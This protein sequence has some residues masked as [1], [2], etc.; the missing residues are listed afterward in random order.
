[1][2]AWEII[3]NIAEAIED[4]S[5][6]IHP[7]KH[8]AI[9]GRTHPLGAHPAYPEH[10]AGAGPGASNYEEVLASKQWQKILR[11]GQQYLGVPLTRQALPVIQ[12][13][14]MAALQLIAE[15]E[16]SHKEELEALA[17]ELVFELS[18][19][20]DAKEAYENGQIAI[21][22]QIVETPDLTGASTSGEEEE[23]EAEAPE[24]DPAAQDRI[25]KMVQRRHLTN[26]LI[27]GSAISN[28]FLFELG[29]QALDRIHPEL[30]KAYGVL[31][32][33]TEIGYWM[34]PQS[35]VIQG[36]RAELQV[37][38]TQVDYEEEGKPP[39]VK[40]QGKHF[41]V[42]I[43]ELIK[44]ITELASL[45]SLPQTDTEEFQEVM[46]KTDLID[47]EAW[48][49]ILGPQLWDQFIEAVDAENERSL[50]LRL[51]RRIQAM[52]NDEFNVFMKG[53]YAKSPQGMQKLRQLA[54]Q[55]KADLQAEK[56]EREGGDWTDTGGDEP[57]G[58]D[59]F[60]GGGGGGF[61]PPDPEGWRRQES[62]V[63]IIRHLID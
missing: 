21:D 45:A 22:A 33:A 23:P 10:Q 37:G 29:G 17:V 44:G 41:P 40:A 51:Y 19:F 31:M 35:A 61:E 38:A 30:R 50:A 43:Q 3:E 26:A 8:Q 5:G 11:K 25:N 52:D 34:F 54:Q 6:L 59:D 39:T 13:K 4:P 24:R 36:A 27:Q 58:G 62:A 42:L 14:L 20:S 56:N 28:N 12:R 2:K 18:E 15:V 63:S 53:L 55:V 32:V 47:L 16:E 48:Q 46:K 49:M 1:M 9:A 7:E 57:A 60:G